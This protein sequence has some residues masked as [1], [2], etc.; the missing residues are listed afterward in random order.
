[1]R[2]FAL[3]SLTA[4][5]GFALVGCGGG[6]GKEDVEKVYM[7]AMDKYVEA[8]KKADSDKRADVDFNKYLD[9]AS[10]DAG[11]ESWKDFSTKAAEAMGE[12]WGTVNTD[13]SKKLTKKMEELGK[14]VQ[15]EAEKKAKGG[16]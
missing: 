13:L 16:E 14:W 12:E 8:W 5:V 3:L 2:T 9:E 1:M 7:G 11:Y 10:K 6:P 15:E 4:L